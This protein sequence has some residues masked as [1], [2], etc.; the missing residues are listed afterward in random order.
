[1]RLSLL[2]A[3]MMAAKARYATLGSIEPVFLVDVGE[4]GTTDHGG[5]AVLVDLV[6]SYAIPLASKGVH[7]AAPICVADRP[8]GFS[9]E[10]VVGAS[11]S[12]ANSIMYVDARIPSSFAAHVQ[13]ICADI[14]IVSV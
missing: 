2:H 3:Y 5:N 10:V 8:A 9:D 4:D 14:T 6:T 13:R 12:G 11:I 1:M 7:L